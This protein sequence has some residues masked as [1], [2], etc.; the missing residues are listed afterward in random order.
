MLL[1]ESLTY[2]ATVLHLYLLQAKRITGRGKA[3][4]FLDRSDDVSPGKDNGVFMFA[5]PAGIS[6]LQKKTES[7]RTGVLVTLLPVVLLSIEISSA[8]P[9]VVISEERLDS[10]GRIYLADGWQFRAEGEPEWKKTDSLES[11]WTPVDTRLPAGSVPDAWE[12][13]GWFRTRLSVDSALGGRPLLIQIFQAG[14]SEIFIDG[15]LVGRLGDPG[16]G[17][18]E[19]MLYGRR[20][21]LVFLSL[22]AGLHELTVR[23]ASEDLPWLH[24]AGFEGG[25]WTYLGNPSRIVQQRA[26]EVQVLTGVQMFFVS[27]ALA[28]SLLHFVLY[29]YGPRSISY[30]YF[31]LFTLAFA[32]N[33]YLDY[34]SSLSTDVVNLVLALRFHRGV[35]PLVLTLGLLF[36]YSRFRRKWPRHFY[37]LI[38]LLAISGVA[39]IIRPVD[40]LFLLQFVMLLVFAEMVRITIVALRERREGAWIIAGGFLILFVFV[41]YD[42]FL[43]FRLIEPVN[44]ILN[45]Y[46]A[47]IAGLLVAMSIYLSRDY[48][49]TTERMVANERLVR[50]Q[51]IASRVLQI[52]NERKTQELEEARRLQLSML[53]QTLP[54]IPGLDVAFHMQTASEVGGDYY[55]YQVGADGTLTIV[56]GDATGHGTRAGIMVAAMKSLFRAELL[57]GDIPAFFNR[58]SAIFKQM[59]LG[60]LFMSL[61]VLQIRNNRLKA[62]V[63]GMPPIMIA[64]SGGEIE[65]IR[66]RGAPLGAVT[67]FPYETI[68]RTLQPGDTVLL[69]SDGLVESINPAG[70]MMEPGQIQQAF[71]EAAGSG[72]SGV[73]EHLLRVDEAWRGNRPVRDDMTFV[74]VHKKMDEEVSGP[75]TAPTMDQHDSVAQ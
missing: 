31:A 60:N 61:G 64:R 49:L 54:L 67:N 12:G 15:V 19:R 20:T 3:G 27:L 72:A 53:P 25:F 16:K 24:R 50:D 44:G 22:E 52:D 7:M 38:A 62:S 58:C 57:A 63:A 14:V 65:E 37:V 6:I 59:K 47:G 71:R 66:L 48:S 28:F 41:L 8:Q 70:E 51:E 10:L 35:Q 39:A 5:K 36:M 74:V 75:A 34:A 73:I 30:L 18:G 69:M 40:N 26:R 33:I 29:L 13:Q 9:A 4:G 23:Y 45:G 43:D 32:L 2:G 17:R 68:E 56:I 55:D 21:D 46:P 11:S 1:P 42:A